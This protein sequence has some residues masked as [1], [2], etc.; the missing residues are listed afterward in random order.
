MKTRSSVPI[1]KRPF[2]SSNVTTHIYIDPKHIKT[3]PEMKQVQE[4]LE[5]DADIE[6]FPSVYHSSFTHSDYQQISKQLIGVLSNP[7]ANWCDGVN[8]TYVKDTFAEDHIIL[9]V[10]KHQDTLLGFSAIN[11]YADRMNLEIICTNNLYKGVGTY[12]NTLINDIA[13][14]IGVE[15]IGLEAVTSAVGF[16]LKTGY[17]CV[18]DLCPMEKIIENRISTRKL[19]TTTKRKPS[20]PVAATSPSKKRKMTKT[21]AKRKTKSARTSS[22]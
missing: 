2:P 10:I 18:D 7:R 13:V 12:M 11:V 21:I 3:L 16:Y 4:K 9:I 14:D 6:L 20:S 5:P 19:R 15:S 17:E 1:E 8:L 22:M